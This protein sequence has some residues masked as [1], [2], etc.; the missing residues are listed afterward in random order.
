MSVLSDLILEW[1]CKAIIYTEKEHVIHVNATFSLYMLCVCVQY[2]HLLETARRYSLGKNTMSISRYL[3]LSSLR[4]TKKIILFYPSLQRERE[5]SDDGGGVKEE[6]SIWFIPHASWWICSG[7]LNYLWASLL[8]SSMH[9]FPFSPRNPNLI[10]LDETHTYTHAP[11][12]IITHVHT[13][14]HEHTCTMISTCV[15]YTNPYF[16]RGEGRSV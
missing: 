3:V 14:F 15:L 16:M 13:Q 7:W 9:L 11:E 8:N 1:R 12:C 5:E 10:R 6:W 4:T 2:V